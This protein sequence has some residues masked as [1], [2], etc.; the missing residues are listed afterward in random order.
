M[1]VER[2]SVVVTSD[3]SDTV[4]VT[5][6]TLSNQEQHSLASKKLNVLQHKISEDF[7]SNSTV[8]R[9]V[10]LKYESISNASL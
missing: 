1:Q 10:I 5:S 7:I 4:V 9:T 6:N 2:N 3:T 8:N